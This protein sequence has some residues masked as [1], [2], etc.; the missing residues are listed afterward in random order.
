MLTSF[1]YANT[2]V[3]N[4]LFIIYAMSKA[5]DILNHQ[6]VVMLKRIFDIVNIYEPNR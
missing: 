5:S 1:K 4:F 2:S 3:F 6:V